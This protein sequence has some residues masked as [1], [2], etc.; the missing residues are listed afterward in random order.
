[1]TKTVRIE[2]ADTNPNSVVVEI[3][4]QDPATLQDKLVDERI[5]K[6]TS[7]LISLHIWST[8]YL[9]IRERPTK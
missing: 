2:N 6:S 4:E 8:R 3:W 1:M 5:L 7:E 9:V